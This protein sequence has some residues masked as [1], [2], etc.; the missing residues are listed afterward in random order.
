MPDTGRDPPAGRAPITFGAPHL[1]DE[2]I[3]EVVRALRC[4]WI[5]T[6]PRVQQ[7]EAQFAAYQGLAPEC[8]AAVSSCTAALHLS[9]LAAGVGTGDEVITTP[10]TFC[11]TVNAILQAG[12][13]PV[14]CDVDSDGMLD[15]Q[16]LRECVTPRTRVLLPVHFAGRPCD[17]DEV[18][19]IARERGLAVIEDCAH[20]VEARF[21]GAAAGTIGDFGCFSFYATKNLTTGEGGMVL[22]RDAQALARVRRLSLH[23]LSQD[24]WRRY[25]T[26]GF[27]DY[28]VLECGFKYNMTDIQAALGLPQLRRLEQA[29][30]RRAAL[31]S[32]Y[33]A[34]FAD[35][36]LRRPQPVPNH[37]R[38]AFHLYTVQVDE[39]TAGI[40]R[41]EFVRR[42]VARGVRP[43][44]HYRAL[45]EYSF[46]RERLGWRPQD[47]PVATAI[48]RS[49]L[50]LP[51]SPGLADADADCVIAAVRDA[52]AR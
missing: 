18:L 37:M 36:P 7:F 44:I 19:A 14:L 33:Q 30:Q 8:A 47:T 23:G 46:Y 39:R 10:L 15:V 45:P 1:L 42:L 22:S 27:G 5:G 35:L 50:S 11:A 2:D 31:W 49:T 34:A 9:L 52:V 24:A 48:G 20:A 3:E 12:A 40:G 4:G 26:G 32:R 51:L 21:R 17:M 41:D 28:D 16:R 29:W 25:E 38:H 6:G 13:T 43:G